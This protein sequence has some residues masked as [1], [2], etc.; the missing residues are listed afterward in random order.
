MWDHIKSFTAI[1]VITVLIWFAA[2]RNV[3]EEQ[4]FQIAV[5]VVSE[6][7]ERYASIAAPPYQTTLTVTVVGRRRLLQ[8]TAE[9]MNST[10]VFDAVLDRSE[11]LGTQPRPIASR[12]LLER[13]KPLDDLAWVIKSV[14]PATVDILVDEFET[15]PNVKVEPTYGDLKVTADPSPAEVSVRLPRFRAGELRRRPVATADA[16]SRIR[17]AVKPDGSFQIKAPLTCEALKE[18]PTDSRI[19]ILPAEE[20]LITGQIESLT[21]TR[22]KGPIQITWS[23]PQQVQK[24]Y[25]VVV[26]PETN[27]RP[28][29]DVTGPKDAIDQLDPRDIRA[30]V[31]VLTAD[32]EKPRTKIRRAAQFV[33]P[34]GFELAAGAQPYEIAFEL[35][36][37]ITSDIVGSDE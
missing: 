24:D 30:F 16:E 4:A 14:E 2:D 28:D 10:A 31:E 36:P 33:F 12:D 26:D 18:L 23:I 29:V 34:K 25:V 6:D 9:L 22:R 3:S 19:K 13:I 27:F 32:T 7:P 21:A 37:R 11:T 8:E 20:V 1:A 35:E 17:A 15:I 5:R